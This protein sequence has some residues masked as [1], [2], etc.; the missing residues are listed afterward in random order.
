MPLLDPP[1][2]LA[3]APP[4]LVTSW[5]MDAAVTS[6]SVTEKILMGESNKDVPTPHVR[7]AAIGS[8]VIATDK[9]GVGSGMA[10]LMAVVAEA[11]VLSSAD[12]PI[13]AS[14][15]DNATVATG[16]DVATPVVTPAD[17]P[18]QP[19]ETIQKHEVLDH[20]SNPGQ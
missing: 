2:S 1:A 16:V 15:T 20:I 13:P 14:G 10:Q 9:V 18:T 8:T 12:T 6:F 7:G 17:V 19:H 11:W 4:R 5:A 3:A